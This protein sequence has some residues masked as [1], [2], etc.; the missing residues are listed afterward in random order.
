MIQRIIWIH[1]HNLIGAVAERGVCVC[2]WGGGGGGG[3]GVAARG[4]IYMDAP[5]GVVEIHCSSKLPSL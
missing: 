2:V 3:V 1:N 5:I 4:Q